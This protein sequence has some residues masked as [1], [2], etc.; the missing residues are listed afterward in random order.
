MTTTL[1]ILKGEVSNKCG[2]IPG[3]YNQQLET[4]SLTN[5]Q[6]QVALAEEKQAA[7]DLAKEK[8]LLLKE[9]FD[10]KRQ[11]FYYI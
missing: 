2:I 1:G 7:K 8:D 9:N 6:L 5:N 10:L 11:V 4:H 3:M